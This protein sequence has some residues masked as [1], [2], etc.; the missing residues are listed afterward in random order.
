MDSA[1]FCAVNRALLKIWP[2]LFLSPPIFL[3][4]LSWNLL[5]S[6]SYNANESVNRLELILSHKVHCLGYFT[7][8]FLNRLQNQL[9]VHNKRNDRPVGSNTRTFYQFFFN[10]VSCIQKL[11]SVWKLAFRSSLCFIGPDDLSAT[12]PDRQLPTTR[13]PAF[14]DYRLSSSQLVKQRVS[15]WWNL[16]LWCENSFRSLW[17]CHHLLRHVILRPKSLVRIFSSTSSEQISEFKSDLLSSS[18]PKN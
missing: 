6:I 12:F 17:H 3:L 13:G 9:D 11:I 16:E 7:C 14:S 10:S 15:C 2:K 18:R 5:P 4:W 8:H 1:S